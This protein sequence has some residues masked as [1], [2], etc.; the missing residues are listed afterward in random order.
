[1]RPVERLRLPRGNLAVRRCR[2]H[3]DGGRPAS[4]PHAPLIEPRCHR[5]V[6]AP[7]QPHRMAA[8]AER[9]PVKV[10]PRIG[11]PSH[12]ATD[13]KRSPSQ[14]ARPEQATS[15]ALPT[16]LSGPTTSLPAH[17]CRTDDSAHEI[18]EGRHRQNDDAENK[19]HR[20]KEP[21]QNLAHL[22]SRYPP[23]R[24][25]ATPERVNDERDSRLTVSS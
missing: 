18:S 24:S 19:Q 21:S 6:D 1:M 14:S 4:L 16:T 10:D 13:F 5:L 23:A 12:S 22:S 25:G 8:S 9:E 11:L 20:N 3:L 2:G 7:V 15:R 17:P